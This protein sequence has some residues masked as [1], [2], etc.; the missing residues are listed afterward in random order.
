MKKL[1]ILL[2]L[3]AAILLMVVILSL[4]SVQR[5]NRAAEP[6]MRLLQSEAPRGD[7]EGS[8]ALW[9]LPYDIPD[10]AER[11]QIMA[12]LGNHMPVDDKLPESLRRRK[13]ISDDEGETLNCISKD[14]DG[15]IVA[16]CLQNV[17]DHADAYRTAVTQ[18]AKLF[19]NADRV[20]QYRN[21]DVRILNVVTDV[22]PKYQYLAYQT[23]PAAVDWLDGKPETAFARICRNIRTGKTLQ[24][25]RGGL[26]SAMIG[27]AMVRQNTKLAADMLAEQPQWAGKLPAH[28]ADAFAPSA[29]HAENFCRIMQVEYHYMAADI[30]RYPSQLS[31]EMP[32]W[33][34]PVLF[35]AERSKTL[36]ARQLAFACEEPARQAF[37][38]DLPINT[39]PEADPSPDPW[40]KYGSFSC[41][42]NLVGCTLTYTESADF[43][44]YARR[45][46]DTH[47]Q[48]R[49]FQAALTLYRLPEHRR[50]AELPKILAQHSS[51]SRQLSYDPE[52][53][54]IMFS[55]YGDY[56]SEE[57][58]IP[59]ALPQRQQGEMAGKLPAL[60]Q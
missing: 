52:N 7:G 13:L 2:T 44:S 41:L 30:A 57:W 23:T 28:C 19:A 36:A 60:P 5:D 20:S 17:R 43:A 34:V 18:H 40:R 24:Q 10:A 1:K 22:I 21:L 6:A 4:L 15:N 58:R 16:G 38:Q 33:L 51:P 54:A 26:V 3:L 25:S 46:Q 11:R 9:L 31:E 39:P 56:P 8:D 50:A 35:S 32:A 59:I 45:L 47:M 37:A 42:R 49:A 14:Q 12:Q 55:V 53:N 27:V 29:D 48:Q